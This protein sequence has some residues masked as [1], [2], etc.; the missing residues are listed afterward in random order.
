[1][2]DAQNIQL[3]DDRAETYVNAAADNITNAT[4]IVVFLIEARKDV[5]DRMKQLCCLDMPIPSQAIQTK[6]VSLP[7]RK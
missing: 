2:A 7:E 6:C 5:Y 1:M 4:Q 3:N